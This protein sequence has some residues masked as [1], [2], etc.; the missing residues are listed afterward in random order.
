MGPAP[1]RPRA[2][3]IAAI[4]AL[5]AFAVPVLALVP[6]VATARV[7]V[8][9]GACLALWL[10][11]LVPAFVPTLLLLAGVPLALASTSEAFSLPAMLTA[12]ADPVMALFFGG[13][14]LAAAARRHG[15]DAILART[16][17]RVSR[18]RRRTLVIALAATSAFLSMWI[19]N[20]AAA[21]MLVQL[22]GPLLADEPEGSPFR[23]AV[24]LAIAF[25]ANFG[26]MATPIG[27]GSNAIAV[28]ALDGR[29]SFAHWMAFALP[30]ATLLVAASV[31]IIL[32]AFRVGGAMGGDAAA[33]PPPAPSLDEAKSAR[34][35]LPVSLLFLACAVAW[36]TEPLHGVSAPVVAVAAAAVLFATSLVG[37]RELRELD[38]PT[39]LLIAGG[40]VLGHVLEASGLLAGAADLAAAAN[41]SPGLA[42]GAFVLT[43][44]VLSALMS[45][46]ATATLL[47]PLAMIA[48]PSPSTAVLIAIGCSLGAPFAIST[49]P[50][51]MVFGAGVRAK[52][53]LLVGLPL[54]LLGA[55]L[56]AL[57]GPAVLGAFGVD[58]TA[59]PNATAEPGP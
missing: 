44:S 22:V 7:I 13:F 34:A 17:V 41:M 15:L 9:G 37:E 57:T 3:S 29:I 40:I 55:A 45:N 48:V 27:S 23:R 38:W 8:I 24:L 1:K 58:A 14:V 35:Q 59:G 2:R 39:L 26:G 30:L 5:L 53:L 46:T 28:A 25:G 4:V 33:L 49:P 6:D 19:S 51:A 36:L 10:F 20:I 11:E 21:A 52:D 18:G 43:A 50:N 16:V 54:M 32:V 56:V 47:V 12:A 31:A 42:L